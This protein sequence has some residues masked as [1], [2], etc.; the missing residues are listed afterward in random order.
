MGRVQDFDYKVWNTYRQMLS[1][2]LSI[3]KG[4]GVSSVAVSDGIKS[5]SSG[6]SVVVG[7][8]YTITATPSEGYAHSS[9]SVNGV[10]ITNGSGVLLTDNR[11]D[12]IAGAFDVMFNLTSTATGCTLVVSD[13]VSTYTDGENIVPKDTELTITATA[14]EGYTL[15]GMT[16]TINGNAFTNGGTH[17]AIA[18][19]TIVATAVEVSTDTLVGTYDFANSTFK[20]IPD[21]GDLS[22]YEISNPTILYTGLTSGDLAEFNYTF[23][24][25]AHTI[26]VM[27]F[28]GEDGQ[29]YLSLTNEAGITIDTD[30]TLCV[31]DTIVE[32]VHT[33]HIFL[34]APDGYLL[35]HT[36]VLNSIKVGTDYTEILSA[37]I[38]TFVWDGVESVWN[39]TTTGITLDTSELVNN[40]QNIYTLWTRGADGLMA[41]KR[42]IA[43]V[44][45]D[46][47]ENS[48]FFSDLV[49]SG[50]T[51]ST[52]IMGN[53]G[54]MLPLPSDV[55]VQLGGIGVSE[56]NGDW[57][58]QKVFIDAN[59]PALPV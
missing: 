21:F 38:T 17:I 3:T 39:G 40:Q 9:L 18:N 34:V 12:I 44:K 6:S 51:L 7:N 15:E 16:F 30:I 24:S 57:A 55:M 52:D 14:S 11:L 29:G 1:P 10:V 49:G 37:P 43:Q 23:D 47:G 48:I 28:V 35:T 56:I 45:V 42:Y 33:P 22:A 2:K 32:S 41:S 20:V 26:P 19:I 46:I 36:L 58:L 59:V 5:Y 8:T 54:I 53:M 13:G 25:V 27:F 4:T 31:M 50:I